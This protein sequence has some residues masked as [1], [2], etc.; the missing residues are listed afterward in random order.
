MPEV[1]DLAEIA[2]EALVLALPLY[3][4]APGSE[5]SQALHAAKGVDP[6]TDS[7]LK[8]FAGLAGLAGRLAGKAGSGSG[9]GS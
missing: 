9:E 8:P 4:K 1:I 6:L 7:D 2:A 3:P 5:F